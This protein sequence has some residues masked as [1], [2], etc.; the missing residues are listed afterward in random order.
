MRDK[1]LKYFK[2]RAGIHTPPAKFFFFFF[3]F[4]LL[5]YIFL[6]LFSS[7]KCLCS[8]KCLLT[9]KVTPCM[10]C[11]FS[12]LLK[13]IKLTLGATLGD[14]ERGRRLWDLY[15]KTNAVALISHDELPFQ[16]P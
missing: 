3:S 13:S 6:A 5:S 1:I 12:V 4:S 11:Q 14:R 9:R 10:N 7:Y 15:N 2:Q 8:L 16:F